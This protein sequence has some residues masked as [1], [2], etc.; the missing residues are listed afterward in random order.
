MA[1]Y[2]P[3][4][5]LLVR[6]EHGLTTSVISNSHRDVS[7]EKYHFIHRQLKTLYILQTLININS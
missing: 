4:I 7:S 3:G 1:A 5:K 6:E 2:G